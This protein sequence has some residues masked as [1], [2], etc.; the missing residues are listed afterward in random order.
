MNVQHILIPT[1]LSVLSLRPIE[2][3]PEIFEG[4]DVTLLCV[5]ENVPIMATGAPFAPPMDAPSLPA[6][7][8]SAREE[9][10]GMEALLP[11]AK[12]VTIETFGD[13]HPAKAIAKW[14]REHNVDLIT[15]STHGRT[16]LRRFALGSVAETILRHASMPVLAFPDRQE[17]HE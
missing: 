7:L 16:G 12:S 17:D 1:D 5:V 3:S 14:A 10:K 4:R 11:A 8:E 6:R 15:L 2:R 13:P 9:M